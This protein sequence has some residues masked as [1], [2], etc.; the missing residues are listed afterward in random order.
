MVEKKR[1]CTT[2]EGSKKVRKAYV[3]EVGESNEEKM[4]RLK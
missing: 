4:G 2:K 1:G 3:I